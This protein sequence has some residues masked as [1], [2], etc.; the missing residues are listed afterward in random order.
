MKIRPKVIALIATLFVVLGVLEI[1]VE[2]HILLSSFAE[3]E[4]DEARTAIRRINYALDLRLKVLAVS[5]SW[6]GNWSDTYLF[7]QDHT[8]DHVAANMTATALQRLDVNLFL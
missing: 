5:A 2:Q 4:H 6:W 3:L 1:F 8:S 7:V